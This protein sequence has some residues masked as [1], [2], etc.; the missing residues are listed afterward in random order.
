MTSHNLDSHISWLLKSKPTVV[1]CG[2]PARHLTTSATKLQKRALD[3]RVGETNT[4]Q[5]ERQRRRFDSRQ[6]DN[7]LENPGYTNPSA[8]ISHAD[9]PREIQRKAD[10]S[11]MARLASASRKPRPTLLHNQPPPAGAPGTTTPSS[12]AA[13]YAASFHKDGMSWA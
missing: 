12:I 5:L 9:P 7:N 1:S 10:E 2:D 13:A 4:T 6:Q 11:N 3:A 8:D